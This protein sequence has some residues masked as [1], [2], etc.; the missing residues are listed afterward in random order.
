M[1][2]NNHKSKEQEESVEQNLN[3]KYVPKAKL[4][5]LPMGDQISA[6]IQKEMEKI[7]KDVDKFTKE[8]SKKFKYLEAVG[9]V[10]GQAAQKIEEEYEVPEEDC[11]RKLIHVLTIIPE[12]NF[13]EIGKI[14][15]EAIKIARGINDKIWTHVMTP[16]DV[17]NLALDS[18][19]D[20][21]EAFAMSFP[22]KDN[23]LLGAL[24]IATIHKS[25][26]LKKFEKYVTS[27]ILAGSIVRGTAT[28]TSDV[29]VTIIID[30]TDVK[31]MPRLELKEKLRSIIYQ[32][33]SEATAI[34][35]VK[36]PLNVQVWLLTDFWERIK[37]AE[38]V[39]FT[40]LRDG[41]PL[42]DRGTFLPW[43]SLLRMGKIK[44]SP[45]SIDLFMSAGDNMENRVKRLMMDA[46]MVDIYWGV[47][48]PSQALLMLY[49]SSPPTH[50]ETPK[51]FNDVFVKKEKLI[52]KKYADILHE[53][54]IKYYKGYEH[55]KIKEVS[56][57]DVDR[58]L[59]NAN[60]FLKRLKELRKQIEKRVQEKGIEQIHAEVFEMLGALLKKKGEKAIIKE[61]EEKLIKTGRFPRRFLLSLEFV[62]KTRKDVEK[63]KKKKVKSS[64]ETEE[65]AKQRHEVDKA[66]KFAR[67]I[68]S[69]LI[70]YNQRCDFLAMDRTRFVI[71]GKKQSA[72][73]FFLN[74][75]FVVD[76]QKIQKLQKGR[77]V[78][79]NT[80]EL[81]KQLGEHQNKEMK[82]DCNV[83][84]DLKKV[85]GDF[86]LVQ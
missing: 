81:R 78:N 50:K 3:D 14:R 18:K 62:A 38:P 6:Q 77:L 37:D 29:D 20:I 21:V 85:F 4:A 43:K 22:I 60:E 86:E 34:A 35:G 58:L 17:W 27:Y 72:E 41:I 25:L 84:N 71:K 68:V 11:K 24:R 47:L 16:V 74:D 79:T 2:E 9:V 32:Y 39:A 53:I 28:P 7:R 23:G 66:R 70:E 19:F 49:G 64:K 67:E 30:D 12:D 26:V 69:T 57:A 5:G 45:E 75:V 46:V 76:A 13:K 15:L 51:M 82:V 61:F 55:G 44:P 65:D 33:I 59:K 83:L 10:P 52:E 40:F 48:Q 42:A 36:N 56:G 31:R 1:E 54:V 63:A 73:V 8:L 80:E